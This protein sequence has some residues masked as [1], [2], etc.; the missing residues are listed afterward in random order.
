MV[1]LTNERSRKS[2]RSSV[3][4]RRNVRRPRF[5]DGIGTSGGVQRRQ[6]EMECRGDMGGLVCGLRE[7]HDW[8]RYP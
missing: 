7:E 1:N 4:D 3:K 2:L 8:Y 5:R 6:I